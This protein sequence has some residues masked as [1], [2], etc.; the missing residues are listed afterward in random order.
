MNFKCHSKFSRYLNCVLLIDIIKIYALALC[1]IKSIPRFLVM[2]TV[3]FGF[4]I[5]VNS[6]IGNE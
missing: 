2:M 4:T 6:K 5:F 3:F 1:P